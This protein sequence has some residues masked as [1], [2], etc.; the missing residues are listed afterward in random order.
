M[1]MRHGEQLCRWLAVAS[2]LAIALS[3]CDK[4]PHKAKAVQMVKLL[5]DAP[6]PPPP[7]VEEKKPE[8]KEEKP[9]PQIAPPKPQETPQPQ[10]LKTDEQ[11]G[12]GAGAGLQAGEVK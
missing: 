6:P 8:P 5:P 3:G 9:Q 10:A 12:A 4:S 2:A 1:R 7:K 11:P